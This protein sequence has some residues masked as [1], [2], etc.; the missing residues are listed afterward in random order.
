MS[1]TYQCP[2]GHQWEDT[3]GDEPSL[4]SG[5]VTC[6]ICG[7]RVQVRTPGLSKTSPMTVTPAASAP[8]PSSAATVAGDVKP[9]RLEKMEVPGYEILGELG[10]GGMGVVYK[11]KQTG[12]K[13]T[14]ALKMVL[15]GGH[16]SESGIARFKAEAEA[17]ARF[18]HPNIVQIYEIGEHEGRP[19]FSMEFVD[20]GSLHG[21]LGGN[22]QPVRES[23]EMLTVLARGIHAAHVAGIVHRDLKPANI[24]LAKD[25]TPKVTDFGLAKQLDEASQL[26]QT[27]DVM[28]TPSYMAPE[29]AAGR[30]KQIGPPADVY[31]LGA[32]L[33]EML[34]GR[35]PFKSE[36]AMDT[37]LQVL[38]ADPVPPSF[39]RAKLPRDVETI[40]M[41]CLQKDPAQRY[42]TALA[43]ADDLQ[44][45]LDDKPIVARPVSAA[46]RTWK[47]VKRH[48][49]LTG[50]MAVVALAGASMLG[51]S[52]YYNFHL[53]AKNIEIYGKNVEISK[54]ND[55]LEE[56]N[57]ALTKE[58][59]EV[60]R[61]MNIAEERRKLAE[62][63]FQ[64][65]MRAVRSLLTEVA[66][67][68]LLNS[69]SM[70]STRK[71][72]LAKA[73]QLQKD[74]L[75]KRT[76][77]PEVRHQVGQ[78]HQL[79]GYIHGRL[80]DLSEAEKNFQQGITQLRRLAEQYPQ[81]PDYRR[82]LALCY[83]Q[84]GELY[85]TQEQLKK[86]EDAYLEARK[87]QEGLTTPA[88]GTPHDRWRLSR[89]LN[90][91]GHLYRKEYRFNEART[92]YEKALDLQEKL[93]Q[94]DPV[95]ADFA[96]DCAGSN[97][98]LAI[99]LKLL[100]DP[101]AEKRY[102]AAIESLEKLVTKEEKVERYRRKLAAAH[103]NRGNLLLDLKPDIAESDYKAAILHWNKLHKD[104]AQVPLYHFELANARNSQ[105]ALLAKSKES[106]KKAVEA[107]HTALQEFKELVE[108]N[109]GVAMYRSCRGAT[110]D[111]LADV[112]VRMNQVKE[113][114]EKLQEAMPFHQEALKSN[115]REPTYLRFLR[116]HYSALADALLAS[117][118]EVGVDHA[119]AAA[120]AAELPL[121]A[122]KVAGLTPIRSGDEARDYRR[123]AVL[124]ARCITA[125]R[126]DPRLKTKE[127]K[128]AVVQP[129]AEQALK[130]LQALVSK[131]QITAADFEVDS[132]RPVRDSLPSEFK[133][134]AEE[135][136]KKLEPKK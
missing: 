3:W 109:P 97:N 24:L 18:Q 92:V 55:G 23:A 43:L 31:A 83:F 90:D 1:E 53:R 128:E 80:G 120:A 39:L 68:D 86:A 93:V 135:A 27:G 88:P 132:L 67:N 129:Y 33:Y 81:P 47:W 20:G 66:E 136:P 11:A 61:Q 48:P 16:A 9:V 12:L 115:E 40:C 30:V 79:F 123:A 82:H 116:N 2:R 119:G 54:L 14:V 57:Q 29:Q 89:T 121:L 49:A 42:A 102:D 25:G 104:F 45:F 84:L 58:S 108:E 101:K 56:S 114:R 99:V 126:N 100:G 22:P 35:P 13:R 4:A 94:E 131:R 60:H 5:Q 71:R 95:N 21:K 41:K 96:E 98:D 59:A 75:Q 110:L 8:T 127:A 105:A 103:T 122:D 28:G 73:L 118:K 74:F 78:A 69:P 38:Y 44:R 113:A 7:D 19:Y 124:L 26:S 85:R 50:G 76:D 112:L 91:L 107:Y 10:R 64:D 125:A 111:N 65:A 52:A 62:A 63:N 34:T 133:K 72:L 6:P 87:L 117:D 15:A 134:L 46:V 17:V 37:M 51:M 77:D 36:T 130:Y 70:D 32:I 106:R